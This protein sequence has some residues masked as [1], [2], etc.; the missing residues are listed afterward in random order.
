MR[1]ADDLA[2]SAP[3]GPMSGP[4]QF[5]VAWAEV[6]FDCL[7]VERAVVF[8]SQLLDLEV[9]DPGLPGWARTSPAV[10]G[11]PVLNFQ[12]VTEPKSTKARVHVDL[13][14]DDLRAAAAWVTSHGGRYTGEAHIYPEGTVAVMQDPEGT[15]FCLVGPP[16]SPPPG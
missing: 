16:G 3:S 15:E 11:G 4:R 13:W 2:E 1:I 7:D 8:W 10:A 14:T 9:A 12:P 6:T 5:R